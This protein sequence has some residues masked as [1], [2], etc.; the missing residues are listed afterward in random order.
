LSKTESTIVGFFLGI[1]CPLSFFIL[2]WWISATLTIYRVFPI[3]ESGIAAVAL[4][5]FCV[6]MLLDIF[7][8][9]K[10]TL[11]FYGFGLKFIV[12]VYLFW[13][14]VAMASLMGLPFNNLVLGTLAGFYVGRRA[15]HART[16]DEKFRSVTRN[17]SALT[18][19]VTSG[20]TMP[21][22]ILGLKE[23]WVVSIIQ[24]MTG[25]EESTIPGPAGIALVVVGCGILFVVQ[26][27]CTRTAAKLAFRIIEMS[28]KDKAINS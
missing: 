12:P 2:G 15:Y 19:L 23:P 20:E 3:S 22:A 9:K 1:A 18:G 10:W 17:A 8:L 13:S 11:K 28:V 4:S 26:S 7:F 21:V 14:V 24:T 6:G 16:N 25:L 5:G 27:W